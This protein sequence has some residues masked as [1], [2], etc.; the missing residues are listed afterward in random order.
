MEKIITAAVLIGI[1][2]YAD[3]HPNLR[4]NINNIIGMANG[5]IDIDLM[6]TDDEEPVK[7]PRKTNK[8]SGT[9][10]TNKRK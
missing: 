7:Q 1:K 6:S 2:R 9:K 8:K 3:R 5:E 4:K 10:P